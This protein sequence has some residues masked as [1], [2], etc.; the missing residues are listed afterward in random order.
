M[1]KILHFL[2][3]LLFSLTI[4]SCGTD[5]EDTAADNSSSSSGDSSSEAT[6]LSAPSGLTA[7][8]G[9]NQVMLD[10][11]AVS[12]ASSYTVYWGNTS[13]ISSSSTAITSISTNNY[14]HSS[15]DNGTTYYYKVAA[16][17]SAGT[18]SLS[19]EVSATTN[20][21]TSNDFSMDNLTI[22]S[23]TYSNAWRS[24]CIA[25]AG[26]DISGKRV[27]Y[28]DMIKYYDN[29]SL[30]RETLFFNDSS[31]TNAYSTG[32][33][34]VTDQWTTSNPYS[35]RG[36]GDN[37]TV[38][39]LSNYFDNGTA[40]PVFDNDSNAVDNGSMYGLIG[41]SDNVSRAGPLLMWGQVYPKSNNEVHADFG[42]WYACVFTG[43]DNCTSPDNFTRIQDN[44]AGTNTLQLKKYS[45]LNKCSV[46]GQTLSYN[47]GLGK[48]SGTL[49]LSSIEDSYVSNGQV[50]T[51]FGSSNSLLI[52]ADPTSY[53][54]FIKSPEIDQIPSGATVSSATLVLT[55]FNSGSTAEARQVVTAWDENSITWNN[56]P[57]NDAG[58]FTTFNT[59][60]GTV[61]I[62]VKAA[63]EAWIIGTS[64]HGLRLL[65]SGGDG[66]DYRSSEYTTANQR[67]SFVIE[68]SYN[69][70]S[71]NRQLMGGSIQGTA[72]NL[73]TAVTTFAGSSL[74]TTDATGTSARFNYTQG[75]TTDGTN[76]YVPDYN[77][78]IRKIVIDNGTVTTLAGSSSGSTDA[79]GTSARFN[80]PLGI[81]TD[82]TNLYVA[83]YYNHRIRKIVIDN[84]T[85]TTLA[86]SSS[87]FTDATG[88]SAKFY[89]P[90]GITTD[91]THLYVAEH[92]NNRIRKIV[93]STGVVTTLAGSSVGLTD[94]TGTSA[95]FSSPRGITTTD[96]TNLYV[97][98]YG[99]HRIRK[100]VIST[101]VVTTLAGSSEG[102]TD[103][104]GTSASF[105]RPQGITTDG[106]N[107]Y[108]A[109]SGNDRIRKIVISTGVVT[110]LAGSSQGST[111]ATG[112][113]ARFYNPSDITTDGTSLYVADTDNHRIRKID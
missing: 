31:C 12:G 95:K 9:A 54:I 38:V 16:V 84:A 102:Y 57:T 97:A 49:T 44:V 19:S 68:L 91:G 79:T 113:S 27:Y 66:S 17:N 13:G 30:I 24:S 23:Q 81:T 104:T 107:L 6:T 37:I 25:T 5:E 105:N 65:S 58:Q 87:G 90:H 43:S 8:G 18:G 51:N 78:R 60:S 103:A 83:D 69:V 2:S 56:R 86:G 94:A 82:G 11:T 106:T 46:A 10:W 52:D 41:N 64:N 42:R 101:G 63:V 47:K 93:I 74:G 110:T 96:G 61:N 76:L 59:S 26:T 40:M 108:V 88:T 98:D 111:D 48:C 80:I 85:V 35:T 34:I 15:L 14:T 29:K 99:N 36:I 20:L 53:E 100:I 77:S 112:T 72:L 75:I 32:T 4:I 62:N 71:H 92:G 22:G 109:D 3:V 28:A 73:S 21:P 67:P 70:D 50:D 39:Q 1:G 7:N 55:S 33:S 89:F 45:V